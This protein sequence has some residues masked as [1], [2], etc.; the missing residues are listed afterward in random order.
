MHTRI[1][2]EASHPSAESVG[3]VIRVSRVWGISFHRRPY[4][5]GEL[6][7]ASAASRPSLPLAYRVILG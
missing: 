2:F 4:H 7:R 3:T 6:E 1:S 5:Q